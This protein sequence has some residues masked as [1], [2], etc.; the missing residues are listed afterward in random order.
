MLLARALTK[1]SPNGKGK[2]TYVLY[3]SDEEN[4]QIPAGIDIERTGVN[5]VYG[6][7]EECAYPVL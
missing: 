3:L 1:I 4:K 2:I 7:D 5:T 6:E